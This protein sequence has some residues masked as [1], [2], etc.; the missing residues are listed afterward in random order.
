MTSHY[1]IQ[2]LNQRRYWE[3]SVFKVKPV[4]WQTV[5]NFVYCLF[6]IEVNQ[7]IF[8]VET[9]RFGTA[10]LLTKSRTQCRSWCSGCCLLCDMCTRWH[11]RAQI[12]GCILCFVLF[13]KRWQLAAEH[14]RELHINA[15]EGF[16]TKSIL[17]LWRVKR[18][19][20]ISSPKDSQSVQEEHFPPIKIF[21]V[22]FC[23]QCHR[24]IEWNLILWRGV[25]AWHLAPFCIRLHTPGIPR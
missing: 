22:M 12:N 4:N 15:Q 6:V 11:F 7:P 9:L 3:W 5:Q 1:K 14:Q 20:N 23:F 17:V 16:V 24:S 25:T 19:N 21:K 18:Y 13:C 10:Y 8:L 2:S